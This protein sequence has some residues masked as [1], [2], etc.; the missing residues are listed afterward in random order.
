MNPV[1][2]HL[3]VDD[4]MGHRNSPGSHIAAQARPDVVAFHDAVLACVADLRTQ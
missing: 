3:A 1:E 4:A 2:H